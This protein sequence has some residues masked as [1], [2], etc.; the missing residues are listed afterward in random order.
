MKKVSLLAE[1]AV[2]VGNTVAT[3]MSWSKSRK[4]SAADCATEQTCMYRHGH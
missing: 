1:I 4:L 3:L 2:F